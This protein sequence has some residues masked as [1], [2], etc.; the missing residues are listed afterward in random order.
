MTHHVKPVP[1]GYHTATPT[2]IVDDAAKAL[3]FYT[4]ALGAKEKSRAAGP[5]GKIVHAEFQLGDSL[6]MLSDEFPGMTTRA[7]KSLKGTTGGVWLYV[8]DMEATYR[9]AIAAG[10][11]SLQAPIDMFWGD[12]HSR[13]LDPFGHEWSISTHTEDVPPAEMEKRM[14]EFMAQMADHH[15]G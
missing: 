2:L 4:K 3:E 9:Q 7:P 8:P 14:K 10:A 6:F 15:D 1:E 12:R 5:D 11:T 13:I